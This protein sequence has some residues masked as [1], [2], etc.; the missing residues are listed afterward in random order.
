VVGGRRSNS[1]TV[2]SCWIRNSACRDTLL[3]GV[4][5]TIVA[6]GAIHVGYNARDFRPVVAQ[7]ETS[8]L[9]A[10]IRILAAGHLVDVNVGHAERGA[11][12]KGA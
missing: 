3:D 9:F 4:T 8:G 12:S 7:S 11:V 1:C 6:E 5:F 2:M 10:Q